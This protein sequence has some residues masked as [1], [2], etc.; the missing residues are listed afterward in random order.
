[1]TNPYKRRRKDIT[2]KKLL[3]P[4]AAG[5]RLWGDMEPLF[6]AMMAETENE[7][8]R[9][10]STNQANRLGLSEN[11]KGGIPPFKNMA[12]TDSSFSWQVNKI[13]GAVADKYREA[14]LKRSTE[15]SNEWAS[16]VNEASK[17]SVANSLKSMTDHPMTISSDFLTGAMSEQFKAMTES[18]VSL[19]KTIH[20]QYFSRVESAVMESITNGNGL[21][22][23][24]P[25]F[26]S[27][28]NGTKNYGKL[29]ALDQTRKAFT[30]INLERMQK[31][32]IKKVKWQHSHGSNDPR[33]LH[34]ELH[35]KIFDIDKPPYSGTLYGVRIH[36]FGGVQINCRCTISPVF[37][38]TEDLKE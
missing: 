4:E 6:I 32:G 19:F 24:L 27:F 17:L 8:K 31:V 20:E 23:L 26:E 22:D 12:T 5:L 36:S 16:R 18:N 35:G 37:D 3:Y 34:Q 10:F 14:I 9:L 29:R 38:F 7:I 30:S 2:G 21:A 1:M 28:S 15:K 25:F 13:L 11:L 33:K